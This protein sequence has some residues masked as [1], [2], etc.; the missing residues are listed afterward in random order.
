M[1]QKFEGP[2]G[3]RELT[4]PYLPKGTTMGGW[5]NGAKPDYWTESKAEGKNWRMSRDHNVV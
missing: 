4:L 5:P 2:G 3:E 1:G